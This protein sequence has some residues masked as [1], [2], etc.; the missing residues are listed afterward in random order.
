M[1][2]LPAEQK[3]PFTHQYYIGI[4]CHKIYP[5]YSMFKRRLTYYRIAP[6]APGLDI[7]HR[8]RFEKAHAFFYQNVFF[9]SQIVNMICFIPPQLTPKITTDF[10]VK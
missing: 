3:D 9:L 4:T 5:I 2:T 7:V 8:F 1:R 6:K 10:V